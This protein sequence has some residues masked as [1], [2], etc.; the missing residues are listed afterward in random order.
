MVAPMVLKMMGAKATRLVLPRKYIQAITTKHPDV[1]ASV[2]ENLP[3]MLSDP[4]F[5]IPHKTGG[6]RI[7][8]DAKTGR[9]EPIFVGVDVGVDGRI[10][11]VSPLHDWNGKKGS[12][13]LAQALATALAR[14]GKI[15]ARNSEALATAKA[16][17]AAAPAILALHRLPVRS[18]IL[19]TRKD[20]VNRL[21][22]SNGNSGPTYSRGTNPDIR[23][24][25][26][27]PQTGIT[28]AEAQSI[29]TSITDRWANAPDVVVVQDMQDAAVPEVV[30][31]EDAKQKSQGATGEPEGFWY[32][33]KAYIVAGEL[34]SPGAVMR[35]LFHE[36]LGHYGL[37][38]TFGKG[39]VPIL[40]QVAATRRPD[41]LTK[42]RE[43]GLVQRDA[44]GNPKVDVKTASDADV[45][46]A[47]SLQDKLTAA[48]EVLA[49]LA[50]S[51][52]DLKI[53]KRLIAL[54]RGFLR[55]HVPGFQAMKMTDADIIA[56]FILPARRFVEQ[57][58]GG[59]P[60]GG[61]YF[62]RAPGGQTNTPAFEKWFGDSKV[63]DA[64]GRPLVM[65][66]GT[67][68]SQQGDA[69]TQFDAYGSNYGLMGQGSYFTDNADLASSYTRKG[70][71]DTPT[72]YPVYLSIKN[73]INMDARGDE[74]AW[75]K[76][77]PDVDFNEYRPEGVKNEDYFRAVEEHLT[78]QQM[79]SYEG[80]EVMQD[81]IRSMGYD[82][83]THRGGARFKTAAGESNTRH[84]VYIAFDPA[85][86]K[87]AT[88]NNGDFD[89]A[90][91]DIRFSRSSRLNG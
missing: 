74:A 38:G 10:N 82:G 89:G 16:S 55:K 20:V 35:V 26:N 50:Q 33:G 59:G 61:L 87:S 44:N 79:P 12:E 14:P 31:Q 22:A 43:Y 23:Y 64:E 62:S 36:T 57:G 78:D 41:I 34:R 48:E 25:R 91:P 32:D 73:P 37:Q 56:N 6:L 19:I 88:G 39:L 52:P 76:A 40:K 4:L 11:T 18:D 77:F 70:R 68:K 47:M 72:V 80:A 21:E 7:Y 90:N 27:Q 49:E 53:V 58:P 65:Y 1:P 17:S 86:I 83:I 13:L 30:R 51:R 54:I 15:Y 2:F 42:A 81:G 71:G 75:Q 5:I 9:G 85:Q 8:V 63:V 69:F 46:A 45:W 24:S 66:H 28:K 3:E 29:V 60:R 84:Q 67:N